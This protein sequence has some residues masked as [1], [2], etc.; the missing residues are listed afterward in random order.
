MNVIRWEKARV[1]HYPDHQEGSTSEVE[2]HRKD[3]ADPATQNQGVWLLTIANM[4]HER[5]ERCDEHKPTN[6]KEV[7]HD[8]KAVF[9]IVIGVCR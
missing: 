5:H 8:G 2:E 9:E 1:E 3:C 6:N 4:S 7:E